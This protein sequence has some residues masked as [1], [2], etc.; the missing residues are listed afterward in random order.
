M[1]PQGTDLWLKTALLITAVLLL[2][3][4]PTWAMGVVFVIGLAAKRVADYLRDQ[5]RRYG[6]RV[7]PRDQ[8]D[9]RG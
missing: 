3:S 6:E 5:E 2:A 7:A 8:G 1:I 9:N 4:L